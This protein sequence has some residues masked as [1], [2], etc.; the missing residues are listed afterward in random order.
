[1]RYERNTNAR[2]GCLVQRSSAPAVVRATLWLLFAYRGSALQNQP[3]RLRRRVVISS[4]DIELRIPL[5]IAMTALIA[6]DGPVN[7]GPL[8]ACAQV[9]TLVDGVVRP[10]LANAADPQPD[11]TQLRP[12]FGSCLG[13]RNICSVVYDTRHGKQA[14]VAADVTADLPTLD[15]SE[16]G[17]SSVIFLVRSIPRVSN[18]PNQYCL[19]VEKIHGASSIQQ[20]NVYGWVIAP[21]GG[22]ALPLQRQVLEYRAESQPRSLRGLAAALWLFAERMSGEASH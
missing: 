17:T 9:S 20:W 13:D 21:N 4:R 11:A 2:H 7:A 19:V 10:L 15:V 6:L 5:A 14:L 8:R 18:D 3:C 22:K 12:Q 16:Q 1:M